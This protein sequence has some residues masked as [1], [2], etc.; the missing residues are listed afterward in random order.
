MPTL[1]EI[2]E[3]VLQ[4]AAKEFHV[5]R[6]QLS[7]DD[8]IFEALQIESIEGLDLLSYIDTHFGIELPD[9]EVQSATSF[10][11]LSARIKSR[12]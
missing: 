1:E 6:E 11:S 12:L 2:T 4:L 3:E 5:P 10:R 9:Y 7:P 8:D